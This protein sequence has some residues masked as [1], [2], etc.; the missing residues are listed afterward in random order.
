M[1]NRR[2]NNLEIIAGIGACLIAGG[3]VI[4][5]FHR[6]YWDSKPHITYFDHGEEVITRR[7][8]TNEELNAYQESEEGHA[9]MKYFMELNSKQ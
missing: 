5:S 1:A 8:D 9:E 7:F 2:R 3:A 6:N 4:H